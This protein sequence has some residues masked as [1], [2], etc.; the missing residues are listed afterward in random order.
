M[1]ELTMWTVYDHPLDYPEFYIAK[2][3]NGLTPTNNIIKNKSLIDLQVALI[4]KGLGRVT[5]SESDEPQII[6]CWL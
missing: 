4:H 1:R 2:E 6:E 5:R 3:F